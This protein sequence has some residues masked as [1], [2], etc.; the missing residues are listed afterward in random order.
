LGGRDGRHRRERK[1]SK[2]GHYTTC[3]KIEILKCVL[4]LFVHST[5]PFKPMIFCKSGMI[6]IKS[7]FPGQFR[8]SKLVFGSQNIASPDEMSCNPLFYL[9]LARNKR[10]QLPIN[11]QH[12]NTRKR[13][14]LIGNWY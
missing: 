12:L 14:L 1:V 9:A 10:K 7:R 11:T 2:T 4:K 13:K 6:G 8:Q 3:P 5:K